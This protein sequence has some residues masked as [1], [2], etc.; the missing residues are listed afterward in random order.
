VREVEARGPGDQG[1]EGETMNEQWTAD[2]ERSFQALRRARGG[3]PFADANQ[4]AAY[5]D[6]KSRRY[7]TPPDAEMEAA[8]HVSP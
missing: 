6:A 8:Q 1:Q 7:D 3:M 5:Q 4:E 2:M